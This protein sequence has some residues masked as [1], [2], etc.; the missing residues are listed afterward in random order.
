MNVVGLKSR[1]NRAVEKL[2]LVREQR[3]EAEFDAM[4][5]SIGMNPTETKRWLADNPG[6]SERERL[7]YLSPFI[8]LNAATPAQQ[9]DDKQLDRFFEWRGVQKARYYKTTAGKVVRL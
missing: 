4:L 2:P 9:W 1:L 5:V 6:V 3:T 7:R 8:R